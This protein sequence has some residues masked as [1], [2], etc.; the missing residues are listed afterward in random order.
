[1]GKDDSPLVCLSYQVIQEPKTSEIKKMIAR[2]TGTDCF[3]SLVGADIR[4]KAKVGVGGKDEGPPFRRCI[5]ITRPELL[6][7]TV[8]MLQLDCVGESTNPCC[9]PRFH[10]RCQSFMIINSYAKRNTTRTHYNLKERQDHTRRQER[11]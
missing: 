4:A 6:I 8:N 9:D 1:M 11:T 7:G 10:H 2:M 3:G 5:I